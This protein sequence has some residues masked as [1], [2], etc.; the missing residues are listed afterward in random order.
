MPDAQTLALDSIRAEHRSLALVI[1]HLKALVAEAVAGRM[2]LDYSLCW[3]LVHYIDTFP[4]ELH[5]PKEDEHFF[6]RVQ[7]RTHDADALIDE[8]KRQHAHEERALG[9]LRKWLGNCEA[10]VPDALQSLE[11]TVKAYADFTWR[12]MRAEEHELFPIA[13]AHLTGAD[14]AAIAQAFTS[15]DDPLSGQSDAAAFSQLFHDIVRRT[16]APLGLGPASVAGKAS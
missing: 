9:Q 13:Q 16:P 3:S 15:H 12:H 5:H 14:W 1:N 4:D 8:L 6:T 11:R 10:G 2:A 7:A